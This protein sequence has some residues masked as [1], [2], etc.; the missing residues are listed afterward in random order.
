MDIVGFREPEGRAR[1]EGV[2]VFADQYPYTASATGLEPALLPR[3]SQAG[4]RDSL[5]ARMN[6]PTDM[7]HIREGMVEGL[8][9]RGGAD[10]IQFRRYRPDPSIE[11]RLLSD[12][13][14]ERGQDPIDTAVDLI[15]AGSPS[16]VSFN[17]SDAD[18]ACYAAKDMGRGRVHVHELNDSQISTMQKELYWVAD[19]QSSI[20]DNRFKLFIQ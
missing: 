16:I 5:V 13:A 6:R 1:E 3:W 12:L 4:G 14:E 20:H 8:A 11:G 9:R 19:I 7:A 15:R 10:R 17:M 18:V 2:Q